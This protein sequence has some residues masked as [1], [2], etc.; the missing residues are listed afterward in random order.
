MKSKVTVNTIA[1][2]KQEEKMYKEELSIISQAILNEIEGYE[3]YKMAGNQASSEGTKEAFL[4]LAG[5]ELKHADYLKKLWGKLSNG[6]E[7]SIE[8]IIESGIEIP[9][10]E[11]YRWGKID[12]S[13]TSVAMS[14]FG[15]GMQME[16]SSIYFYE[17]AKKKVKSKASME[18]FDL[19]IGWEKVHLKQFSEQ[20]S[21]LKEDWWAEQG[22][23]PF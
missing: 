11:I 7:V 6:G 9:S 13:S 23:A 2:S 22:F 4:E 12:E 8:D 17:D 3:F 1:I 14:V 5:E 18:L 15:I 10:P 16:Q 21:I 19:L 20:Y